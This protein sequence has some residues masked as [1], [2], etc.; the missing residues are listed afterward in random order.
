MA[1]PAQS[2]S[3]VVRRPQ[4]NKNKNEKKGEKGGGASDHR[5]DGEHNTT[6]HTSN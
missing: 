1:N 3:F 5:S 6:R 2:D 4:K